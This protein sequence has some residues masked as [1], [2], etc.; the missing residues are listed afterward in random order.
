MC[1]VPL[2]YANCYTVASRRERTKYSSE[3]C[4]SIIIMLLVIMLFFCYCAASRMEKPESPYVA[5]H[6]QRWLSLGRRRKGMFML[7][8]YIDIHTCMCV[9]ACVGILLALVVSEISMHVCVGVCG[10]R[11]GI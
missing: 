1:F 8:T 11:E 5:V 6:E 3:K 10:R 7:G 4:G 2:H 9:Y